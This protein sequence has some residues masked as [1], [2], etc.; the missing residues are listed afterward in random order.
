MK[1]YSNHLQTFINIYN[2]IN[3]MLL[4]IPVFIIYFRKMKKI[5][6]LI[7]LTL[8]SCSKSDETQITSSEVP[9]SNVNGFVNSGKIYFEDNTCKCPDALNGDKDIIGEVT[10]TAVNNISIKDEIA[11]GNYNLCTT[12]VTNMSGESISGVFQNFFNNNSFNSNINFW[13][14]SNVTNMDGMFYNASI[15]NQNISNWDTSKVDNMGS[16]FKNATSFNQDISSWDTSKVT[17]MLDL[18]RAATSFNQDISSWDTS[19]A[20]SMSK[21]FENATSFNQDISSWCVL[22]FS[23]EPENFATNS[24]LLESY[25]PIWGTC[26]E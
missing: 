25:Q 11:N 26:P 19:S 4:S 23:E 16:M 15:F 13:D 12:L 21:M 10:Y 3:R 6:F 2:I 1:E 18:F 14:V 24:P 17:K 22:N 20:T 8:I 9:S 5:L 7:T